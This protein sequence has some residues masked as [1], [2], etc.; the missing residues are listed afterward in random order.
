MPLVF[1]PAKISFEINKRETE[2]DFKKRQ[3]GRGGESALG[4]LEWFWI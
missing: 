2:E 4:Y 1:Y 3:T